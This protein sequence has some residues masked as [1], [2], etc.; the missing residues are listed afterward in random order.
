MSER[1]TV[2][3]AGRY[4]A[5]LSLRTALIAHS[6][7][8]SGHGVRL[9]VRLSDIL[10]RLNKLFFFFFLPFGKQ[11]LE[12]GSKKKKKKSIALTQRT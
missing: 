11:I 2:M 8:S 12:H 7:W 3:D 6:H 5:P 9:F 1:V 10:E 4:V